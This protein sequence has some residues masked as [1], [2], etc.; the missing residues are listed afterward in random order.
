MG[1]KSREDAAP[2]IEFATSHE[3]HPRFHED[4]RQFIYQLFDISMAALEEYEAYKKSRGLIDYTDMEV[5]INQLLADSQVQAVL[6]EELDLLMV[7]EFQDTSP[8]QLEIFL[9]L[10]QFA[11]FS[12]WVGDPKQSIYGFR[13]ADPKLM[14]AIIEQTGGI[15]PADIQTFSWRSRQDIVYATNALFT[16]AFPKLPEAQVALEPKRQSADEPDFMGPAL[17]HW[18]FDYDGEG[19]LP[20]KPWMENCLAES[21]RTLLD[22]QQQILPKGEKEYRAIQP[23]DIAVLCRS[24]YACQEVADALHRTGL[25]AAISR[26]GLL[27]TA[28]S[29]LIL[30]C[31]KFILNKYDS[32]S[33]AEILLLA[34]RLEIEEIIEDRL[35][36]LQKKEEA[37]FYKQWGET[38]HYIKKLN[39]L[40]EEVVEL[41]S[42]EILNL[43]LE[44]LDLRRS[45]SSWGKVPQ[46]LGN[47][48]E[49]TRLALQYEEACNRLH[50]AASLGGFLLW[51]GELE[52]SGED[53]QASG[54]TPDAVNVLTYHKSKGLEYPAVICYSLENTLR[55]DVWGIKIIP[56]TDSVDLENVLGN[57]WLR[58][59]INP[60]ADQIR[61]TKLDER[62]NES[63]ARKE[64]LQEA[65]EE[66]AR[67]M[68]VGIT[69]ARDYLVFPSRNRPT[70]WL[71]RV[72]HQGKEEFP[73]L[74]P[75][76]AESPWHWN[77]YF[78][79]IDS[80][81]FSY[82]LDFA[83]GAIEETPFLFLTDRKGRQTFPTAQID[84]RREALNELPKLEI[85]QKYAYGKTMA[86]S[87]GQDSYQ[88]AK[89]FKAFLTADYL[90][91]ED[92]IRTKMAAHLLERYELTEIAP[93]VFGAQSQKFQQEVQASFGTIRNS[94]RKFPIQLEYKGRQFSTIID[95]VMETEN[96]W[97]ILQH[98]GFGGDGKQLQ[99]KV[100]ELSDWLVLAS[101]AIREIQGVDQVR[102]L[103]HFVLHGSFLEMTPAKGQLPLF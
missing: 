40:R 68:Y 87:E 42:A 69:R 35:L 88:L 63:D 50:T 38:N 44:E 97:V 53:K 6:E 18:H 65:L 37:G 64:A 84:L 30:A 58:Y 61:R 8:I 96:G 39:E 5:L 34:A 93:E 98:S 29:K 81:I 74:D 25:K 78:L 94:W 56:E 23:G 77:D 3:S 80:E 54:E 76:S 36:F 1:A 21:I 33:V 24:N 32:L 79:P 26:A 48:E 7:D 9:K 51:L 67:L 52:Q 82:P 11:K 99:R 2:L 90:D 17:R 62:L 10:S 31:L 59:W 43:V 27:S 92:S 20:G 13:G 100:N 45:I 47:V 55:G 72:W 22:R 16:R 70:K 103:L 73:T 49:L 86:A 91:Y 102:C 71:N 95:L 15:N 41:S 28:E 75:G 85:A 83:Q 46:R 14:Q 89:A 57:R 12:V 4:I 66:E 19:R 60:Y 101:R